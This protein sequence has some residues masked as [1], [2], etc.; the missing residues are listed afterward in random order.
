MVYGVKCTWIWIVNC[1]LQVC[2]RQ[3]Y[4]LENSHWVSIRHLYCHYWPV[5]SLN[6]IKMNGKCFSTETIPLMR[7][8]IK[9]QRFSYNKVCKIFS[10]IPAINVVP[11]TSQNP[12]TPHTVYKC[13]RTIGDHTIKIH[14]ASM[15]N[16]LYKFNA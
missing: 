15:K 14:S 7:Y 4:T 2:S 16:A 1:D 3:V 8:T 11:K 5:R 9:T 12:H 10:S 6:T 13:T